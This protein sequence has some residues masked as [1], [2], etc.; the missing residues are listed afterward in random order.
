M[1]SLWQAETYLKVKDMERAIGF[2]EKLLGIEV[3]SRYKNRWTSVLGA[4]G[5]YNPAFDIENNVEITDF[6]R[7]TVFGNNV[8]VVF[9]TDDIDEEHKRV[10]S[11]GARNVSDIMRINLAA[12]YRF[13]HFQDTEGNVIEVGQYDA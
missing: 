7:E 11:I 12:P 3:L 1:G 10:K 4:F 13:F 6:D 5:L 8:I 2:Y 9:H